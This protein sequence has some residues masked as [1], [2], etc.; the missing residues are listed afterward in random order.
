M[1]WS[2]V[3][4]QFLNTDLNN[5]NLE[6]LKIEIVYFCFLKSRMQEGAIP[7]NQE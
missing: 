1:Y 6:L 4:S 7:I 2:A 5:I 3:C